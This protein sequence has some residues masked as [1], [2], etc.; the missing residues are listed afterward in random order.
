MNC[1]RATT[2]WMK[3]ATLSNRFVALNALPTPTHPLLIWLNAYHALGALTPMSDLTNAK[4]VW[5]MKLIVAIM[6]IA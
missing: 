4:P 3:L 5:K 6:I 2:A 1:P